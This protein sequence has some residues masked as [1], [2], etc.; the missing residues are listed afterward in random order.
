MARKKGG[1]SRLELRRQHEAAEKREELED[2]DIDET[3]EELGED[4]DE[5]EESEED[6]ERASPKKAKKKSPKPATSKRS[7][8]AKETRYRAVWV[9]FDNSSKRVETF[10][11]NKKKE[12]EEFLAKKIEEKKSTYYMNLVKDPYES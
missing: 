1:P 3:D 12:A 4:L 7:R 11:Y 9:I 2:E 6:S 8:A 5:D 10:P